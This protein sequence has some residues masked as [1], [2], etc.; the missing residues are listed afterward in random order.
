LISSRDW[1]RIAVRSSSSET[2]F[3]GK[4]D[5]GPGVLSGFMI[6]AWA[7]GGSTAVIFASAMDAAACKTSSP[8]RST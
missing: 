4:V 5:G 6:C 2:P 1:L 7:W 8:R 3:L